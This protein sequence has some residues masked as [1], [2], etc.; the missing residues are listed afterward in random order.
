[1]KIEHELYNLANELAML[2]VIR[3]ACRLL[4]LDLRKDSREERA[5]IRAKWK[6]LRSFFSDEDQP[7]VRLL[8]NRFARAAA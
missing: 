3:D 1:M 4:N 6:K 8:I 7:K 5:V 2:K